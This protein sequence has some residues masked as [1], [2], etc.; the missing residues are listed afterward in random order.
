MDEQINRSMDWASRNI[1]IDRRV[2]IVLADSHPIV[3]YGLRTLLQREPDFEVVAEAARGDEVLD[4]VRQFEPDVLLLDPNMPDQDGLEVLMAL[5]QL[6][7][8]PRVIL[9]AAA[10]DDGVFVQAMR[11][12]CQGIVLKDTAAHLII[13]SIRVV[14]QGEVW[15]DSQTTAAV[16]KKFSA[17]ND[18]TGEPAKGLL[19][20]RECEVVRLVSKGY[21]NKAISAS[22][23][24]T[25]QTVKNHLHNIFAKL[26]CSDRLEL[27]LCASRGDVIMTGEDRTSPSTQPRV[28]RK[29][30]EFSIA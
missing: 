27:A 19:S 20:P 30:S 26:G 29:T 5:Q 18:V 28:L 4:I 3:R 8:R 9:L 21:K 6:Q 24:I 12:G 22:L 13:K 10:A 7:P 2:R 15:L 16:L 14:R 1:D 11:L 25:E 23:S 17:K